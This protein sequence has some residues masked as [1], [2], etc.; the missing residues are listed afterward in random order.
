MRF[1]FLCFGPAL[2]R[3][4]RAARHMAHNNTITAALRDVLTEFV[5]NKSI[6]PEAA[7][8]RLADAAASVR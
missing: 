6:T 3:A 7:Q 8:K 1:R 4:D 2:G 5:H